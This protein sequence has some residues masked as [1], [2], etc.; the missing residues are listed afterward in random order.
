MSGRFGY[1]NRCNESGGSG[2]K[3]SNTSNRINMELKERRGY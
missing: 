2:G 3:N 1:N